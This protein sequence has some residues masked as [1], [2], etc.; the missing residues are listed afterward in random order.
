MTQGTLEILNKSKRPG[1]RPRKITTSIHARA[2]SKKRAKDQEDSDIDSVVD[3]RPSKKQKKAKNDNA[4]STKPSVEPATVAKKIVVLAATSSDS[5]TG[6]DSASKKGLR[7]RYKKRSKQPPPTSDSDSAAMATLFTRR[8][9]P[10]NRKEERATETEVSETSSDEQDPST[11]Q[12]AETSKEIALKSKETASKSKETASKS[13]ETASK[14]KET[15]SKSKETASKPKEDYPKGTFKWFKAQKPVE[16]G[17]FAEM[18]KTCAWRYF[19]QGNY[20]LPIG[21]REI[22]TAYITECYTKAESLWKE[23]ML[24]EN[25]L[26]EDGDPPPRESFFA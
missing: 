21:N 16:I 17:M 8:T 19:F 7:W 4:G 23:S 3:V 2:T 24:M 20:F 10:K 1:V 5:D 9:D 26:D 13:K 25:K 18:I 12:P 15:A 11:Q 6:N 22:R 14:S